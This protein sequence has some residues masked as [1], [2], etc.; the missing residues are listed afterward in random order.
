[1]IEHLTPRE[2]E[3]LGLVVRGLTNPEIGEELCISHKTVK[4]HH[5]PHVLGKLGVRNRT[6]AAVYA[7]RHLGY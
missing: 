7:V 3:V 2:E 5:V 6:Q 4:N 1:M